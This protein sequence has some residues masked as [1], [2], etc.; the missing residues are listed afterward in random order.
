MGQLADNLRFLPGRMLVRLVWAI[1]RRLADRP[2]AAR[3]LRGE[4]RREM[5]RLSTLEARLDLGRG[6]A[7]PDPRGGAAAVWSLTPVAFRRALVPGGVVD[8][9]SGS[10][11][12]PDLSLFHDGAP[13][14]LAWRQRPDPGA[15]WGAQR[16][17]L[18]VYQFTGSFLSLVVG[19]PPDLAARARSGMGI[20]LGFSAQA[21]RPITLYLRLNI[22]DGAHRATLHDTVLVLQGT[23]RVVFDLTSAAEALRGRPRIWLDLIFAEP[24]MAEIELGR[25]RLRLVRQDGP[26]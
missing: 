23:R 24:A 9:A 19:V 18:V 5:Q 20:E 22:D 12:G 15:G 14:V 3:R 16:L 8:P 11:I 21:T 2:A 6:G 4:I 10:A 13:A 17:G 26:A 1:R 25:L 7:D